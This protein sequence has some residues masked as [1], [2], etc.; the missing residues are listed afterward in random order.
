MDEWAIRKENKM[1]KKKTKTTTT[2]K[3]RAK[4]KKLEG[5]RGMSAAEA[6][7]VKGGSTNTSAEPSHFKIPFKY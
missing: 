7:K 3:Q 5:A 2:S 4:V 1:P 6:K